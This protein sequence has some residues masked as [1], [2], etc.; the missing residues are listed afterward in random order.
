ML[1]NILSAIQHQE[2]VIYKLEGNS[3]DDMYVYLYFSE[4]S[5]YGGH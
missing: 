4:Y 3:C 2:F 1:N 5:Q